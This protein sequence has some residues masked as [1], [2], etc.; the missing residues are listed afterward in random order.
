[1]PVITNDLLKKINP[2]MD[3]LQPG[4]IRAFDEQVSE[5]EDIIKLTLGEPDL[6]AD[7]KSVV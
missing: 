4:S 1:M 2:V 6:Y 7:R 5:I 3:Q